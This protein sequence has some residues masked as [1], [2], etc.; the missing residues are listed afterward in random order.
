MHTNKKDLFFHKSQIIDQSVQP[1]AT[2]GDL[3]EFSIEQGNLHD[4]KVTSKMIVF[5]NRQIWSNGS[6]N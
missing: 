2:P 1:L 6:I 5:K 3:C 4:C